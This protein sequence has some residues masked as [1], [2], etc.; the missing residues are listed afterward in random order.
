MAQGFTKQR[1][2]KMWCHYL[3]LTVVLMESSGLQS[4]LEEVAV[5]ASRFSIN[6]D[7]QVKRDLWCCRGGFAAVYQGTLDSPHDTKIAVKTLPIS[8][9]IGQLDIYTIALKVGPASLLFVIL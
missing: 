1:A 8:G 2:E 4:A 6:L 7:G 3:Q 9:D 5:Y